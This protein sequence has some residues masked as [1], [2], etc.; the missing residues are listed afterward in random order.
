MG[1]MGSAGGGGDALCVQS[2][3]SVRFQ[4]LRRVSL[5]DD[6]ER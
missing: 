5:F 2:E 3:S 4:D 1:S 6:F